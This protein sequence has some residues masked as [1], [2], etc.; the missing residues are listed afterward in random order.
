MSLPDRATVANMAPEYGATMGFFPVDEQTLAYLRLSGRPDSLVGLVERYT[1]EQGL[2][3]TATAP[4][5]TFSDVV[6][7]DLSSIEPCL[8]GPKR[9]QDRVP[10]RQAAQGFLGL[11]PQPTADRGFAVPADAL[12]TKAVLAAGAPEVGHGAVVIAAITSCTNTSNP[13]VLLAAGLLAKKAVEKGLRSAPWVKTSLAPGSR[14]VTDYLAKAG[15]SEALDR[16]GFQTVGY[17]CTTCIGNSG[18]LPAEVSAGL[19]ASGIVAAAVISGNRNFEGRVHPEVKANYLASPP[20]VVAY[21]IAGTV[22][23]DLTKEPLGVGRDGRPVMLAEVWPTPEEI[24]AAHAA[25]NSDMYRARYAKVFQ[26]NERWN[27]M[28]APATTTYPWEAAS[29]YIQR[30]PFFAHFSPKERAFAPIR[31]ARVLALLGDS[32]TTDHIS[33]AGDIPADG[34]AGR[35]LLEHGVAR[36]DFN[37]FGAR[38][39]NDRIMTRGTFANIRLRNLLAPGTEGGVTEH[40]PTGDRVSIFEAAERYR[41]A[42]TSLLVLAG[43]EYGTGSSRD[44]AAKGTLL[45]GVRAVIAESF[46]R[47]HRSNLVGMG[48]LPLEFEPG[49]GRVSLGLTG[50]ETFEIRGVEAGVAPRSSLEVVATDAQGAT[51]LFR[52]R[53]RVDT[54]VEAE[55]LRHGGILPYVLGRLTSPGKARGKGTSARTATSVARGAS[56]AKPRPE[57]KAKPKLE[58]MATAQPMAKARP[59]PKPQAKAKA[60]PQAM[61]K[62]GRKLAAT[63]KAKAQPKVSVKARGKAEPRRKAKPATKEKPVRKAK[64][65]KKAKPA[66]RAPARGSGRRR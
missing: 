32:V 4:D 11:L 66:A 61:A 34:P 19:R 33:P 13:S 12:E 42:G 31:G 39:G 16:L 55:Y 57:R 50:R 2:F 41:A 44:W 26:G 30:P 38:R 64:P 20:L 62:P 1:K 23:R 59:K 15:L 53:C 51:K 58:P 43:K 10:L 28:K 49:Q 37:S 56:A 35:Y 9:P 21:A 18:P 60:K 22:R 14:V 45:L 17:G 65:S 3:R 27:A 29:T 40:L 48:V 25:L 46:E 6:E 63:P 5:P 24:S 52:V 7:L 8:A 36:A 47:I 54:P